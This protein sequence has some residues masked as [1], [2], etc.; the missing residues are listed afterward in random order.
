MKP[1]SP[2]PLLAVAL[3]ALASPAVAHADFMAY[4]CQG[5]TTGPV[6]AVPG[7]AGACVGFKRNRTGRTRVITFDHARSGVLLAS[8]DGRTVVM[9][10]SYLYGTRKADGTLVEFDGA[11]AERP[12]PVV[13]E[14]FRDGKRLAQH[15]LGALLARPHLADLTISH[16]RWVDGEPRLDNTSLELTTTSYRT[17]TFSTRTGALTGAV[18][19]PTWT[20]CHTLASGTVDLVGK[21]LLEPYSLKTGTKVATIPFAIGPGVVLTDRAYTKACFEPGGSGLVLTQTVR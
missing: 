12:D 20:R 8:P 7:K 11:G 4:Q 18:D 14:V 2:A 9:V 3:A 15:R 6:V 10:Q 19:T 16:V 17:L 1:T 21:R 5:P 13:L